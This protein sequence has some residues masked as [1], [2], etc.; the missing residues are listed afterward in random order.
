MTKA[1]ISLIASL[2]A[3]A[4]TAAAAELP[5]AAE[6]TP[7]KYVD[8][9][10]LVV[11]LMK[12]GDDGYAWRVAT[13]IYGI[14][15][16]S[17]AARVQWISK[18]KVVADQRCPL[19]IQ[20]ETAKLNCDWEG[21]PLN[22]S[23]DVTMKLI[24]V[25][26]QAEKEF[27]LRTFN[28]KVEKFTWMKD[29]AYQVMHDDNLGTAF[30]WHRMTGDEYKRGDHNWVFY[31]WMSTAK[32]PGD[33]QFRCT[34]NGK[35]I[36]DFKTSVQ[37]N[38]YDIEGLYHVKGEERRYH[39]VPMIFSPDRL[40]F[41]TRDELK[42]HFNNTDEDIAR[43]EWRIT[44]EM[45][46]KWECN[47]RANGNVVRQ[48]LFDVN[49]KGRIE[50]HAAQS[51]PGFPKL[52]PSVV[53]VDMRLPAKNEF[54]ERVRPDAIKKSMRYGQPWPKHEAFDAAKKALPPASGL[55]DPK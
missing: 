26:D 13:W 51:A 54:D 9:A 52:L 11:Y 36:D 28:L 14:G 53:W 16:K 50:P 12:R 40:Y 15:S 30:V 39:W 27:L 23:G 48:F 6:Q 2:L 3:I 37:T 32:N 19:Q 20:E 33:A 18:G 5:L 49:D 46:G 47:L 43:G 17:D 45:P 29:H 34:V 35:R 4:S 42:K 38:G 41:G 24:F 55:A 44:A 8:E 10:E 7:P 31:F 25:D 22:A 1:K 21:K